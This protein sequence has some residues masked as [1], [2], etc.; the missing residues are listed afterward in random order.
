MKKRSNSPLLYAILKPPA[1]ILFKILFRPIIKGVE[2]IPQE[3]GVVLAGNHVAWWDCFPVMAGTKRCIHFLAKKE[4]FSTWFTKHFFNSAGL[5]PVNRQSKDHDALISAKEYL[6]NGAVIGI[7]PEGTTIKPDGVDF[8]PFKIGAVKMAYDTAVPVVPFTISGKYKLFRK[9]ISIEFH[10][11]VYI[12][13]S[14]LSEE[15]DKLRERVISKYNY[16]LCN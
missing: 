16:E 9:K 3:G 1:V 11:P 7:F 12:T 10:E 8:L 14:N 13:C 15:N 6:N 2:N 5:I 4:I